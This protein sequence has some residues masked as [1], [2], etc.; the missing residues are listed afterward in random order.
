[1]GN[2]RVILRN[3]AEHEEIAS[4]VEMVGDEV[5]QIEW[6]PKETWGKVNKFLKRRGYRYLGNGRWTKK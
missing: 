5:K 6:I 1:D 4:Y 3:V 2:P